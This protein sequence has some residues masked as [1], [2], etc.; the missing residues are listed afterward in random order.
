[1]RQPLPARPGS[2]HLLPILAASKPVLVA[3]IASIVLY[4]LTAREVRA[5]ARFWC[6]RYTV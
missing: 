3:G 1:M 6:P 5:S 4:L 2:Y